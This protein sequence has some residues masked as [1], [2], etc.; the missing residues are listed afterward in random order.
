MR[1][2]TF[3]YFGFDNLMQGCPWCEICIARKSEEK[4]EQDRNQGNKRKVVLTKHGYSRCYLDIFSRAAG[5]LMQKMN[6]RRFWSSTVSAMSCWWFLILLQNGGPIEASTRGK[7]G[8]SPLHIWQNNNPKLNKSAGLSSFNWFRGIGRH[9]SIAKQIQIYHPFETNI[10]ASLIFEDGSCGHYSSFHP[11]R[12]LCVFRRG[13]RED[14]S[15]RMWL[16]PHRHH[17]RTFRAQ[18]YIW[19]SCGHEDKIPCW[20]PQDSSRKRHIWLSYDDSRGKLSFERFN[21]Q[22]LA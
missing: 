8:D 15:Q 13:V 16:A 10:W 12:R 11:L 3:H 5:C 4:Y 19:S 18:H 9:Q 7:Q 2:C 21:L 14:Y 6:S 20:A 1:P 17:G 22:Q